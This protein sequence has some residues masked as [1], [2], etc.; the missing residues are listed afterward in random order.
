MNKRRKEKNKQKIRR[1]KKINK[2][3]QRQTTKTPVHKN[4]WQRKRD[5]SLITGKE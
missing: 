5:N 4:M 1:R 2:K 3:N